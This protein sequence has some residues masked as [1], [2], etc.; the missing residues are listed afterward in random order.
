MSAVPNNILNMQVISAIMENYESSSDN[1]D[2][3]GKGD[4]Y[5]YW[6][7]EVIKQGGRVPM[8][9]LTD[10]FI[11]LPSQKEDLIIGYIIGFEKSF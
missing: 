4:G 5:Q 10:A 3:D 1:E 8:S 2:S 6:V 11:K 7:N 9:T